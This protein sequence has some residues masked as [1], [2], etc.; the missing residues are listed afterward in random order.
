[1][2]IT[3]I[4]HYHLVYLSDFIKYNILKLHPSHRMLT[5]LLFSLLCS[6][7]YYALHIPWF[8]QFLYLWISILNFSL[9][10][11]Y[12]TAATVNIVATV[13]VISMSH[14]PSRYSTSLR[15]CQNLLQRD[16]IMFLSDFNNDHVFNQTQLRS[17]FPT[18]SSPVY[19]SFVDR[20]TLKNSQVAWE[21][22]EFKTHFK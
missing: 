5:G 15:N 11:S 16:Y 4:V 7:L 2:H 10:F 8:F 9:F 17:P 14:K 22:I 12:Y 18:L 3:G 21:S 20:K 1:M 13:F 19:S 6:I